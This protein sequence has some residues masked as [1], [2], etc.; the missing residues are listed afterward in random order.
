MEKIVEKD[1]VNMDKYSYHYD[2]NNTNDMA[3]VNIP[4]SRRGNI[5][6]QIDRYKAEQAR[7]AAEKRKA[8]TKQFKI[9]RA[10]AKAIWDTEAGRIEAK[11]LATAAKRPEFNIA[12]LKA[13]AK[14]MAIWEPQKFLKW[15]AA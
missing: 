11:I 4:L 6:A 9:D 15:M 13:T 8:D 12:D 1:P 14:S 2:M 5:D 10:A 7:A 3:V